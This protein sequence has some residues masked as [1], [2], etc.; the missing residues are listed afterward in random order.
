[1]L[2]L[3]ILRRKGFAAF[4]IFAQIELDDLEFVFARA[5]L[6]EVFGVAVWANFG[7]FGFADIPQKMPIWMGIFW[8]FIASLRLIFLFCF[9]RP[10]WP[11]PSL[12]ARL[13]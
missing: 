5:A 13:A 3:N 7:E 6:D 12:N 10:P 11:D 4:G 1:M 9:H 2:A 8:G